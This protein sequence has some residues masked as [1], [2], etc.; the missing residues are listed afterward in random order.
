MPWRCQTCKLGAASIPEECP[1]HETRR[2]PGTVLLAEGEKPDVVWY[3]RRGRVALGSVTESGADSSCA[4]RGPETLLGLEVLLGDPVP[5]QVWTL[6]DVV[7]CAI[8][9]GQF[10][11][12]TGSL[13]T[14]MGAV[15]DLTLREAARRI[16]DRQ[17]LEGTAV[18]RIARF[19]V[20][21]YD[22]GTPDE[23]LDLQQRVIARVLSMRPETLSRAMAKLR[24]ENALGPGRNVSIADID[25]LRRIASS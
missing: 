23:P 8:D 5:Y 6:T 25:A 24:E 4:V 7:L 2:P 19:L 1:F 13:Q 21:S 14:P 22:A 10:R 18:Q 20:A 3:L 17:A 15:L 16:A 11:S 12:W 9:A